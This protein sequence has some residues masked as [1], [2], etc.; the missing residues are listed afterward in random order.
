LKGA[1]ETSMSQDVRATRA[2]NSKLAA[3]AERLPMH[4]T[5]DFADADRGFPDARE[6][7][8]RQSATSDDG[9]SD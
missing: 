4:D 8:L 1:L 9:A 3:A 6:L 2:I 7:S 5:Q